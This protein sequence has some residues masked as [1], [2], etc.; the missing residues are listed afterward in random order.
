LIAVLLQRGLVEITAVQARIA[1]V[2]DLH[3]RAMLARL[4]TVIE[5]ASR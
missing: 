3:M 2:A 4:Q 1:E 5:S